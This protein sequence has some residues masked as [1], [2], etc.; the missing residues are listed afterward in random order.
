[1]HLGPQLFRTMEN[2][3]RSRAWNSVYGV[4]HSAD[5]IAWHKTMIQEARR[6]GLAIQRQISDN[7]LAP[8]QGRHWNSLS[9]GLFIGMHYG[10]NPHKPEDHV[11]KDRRALLLAP[12]EIPNMLDDAKK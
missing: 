6:A 4:L 9:N 5:F 11:F 8:S 3:E 7:H 12:K 10:T 2:V 1:M